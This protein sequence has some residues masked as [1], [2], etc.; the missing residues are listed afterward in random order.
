MTSWW[1][2]PCAADFAD[3]IA[4]DLRAGKSVVVCLPDPHPPGLPDTLRERLLLE[5]PPAEDIDAAGDGG[6][7]MRLLAARCLDR[8]DLAEDD[9][10]ERLFAD[11]RFRG[12]FLFV[13]GIRAETWPRWSAFLS[14]FEE[15]CRPMGLLDRTAIC[16]FLSGLPALSP[17][18]AEVCLSVRPWR[19]Q[20]SEAD[21]L[22]HCWIRVRSRAWP[23]LHRKLAA[24]LAAKVA[25]WDPLIADFLLGRE[26]EDVLD[27]APALQ[28]YARVRGWGN[29][30]RPPDPLSLWAEGKADM[31][32]EE[33]RLHA[34]LLPAGEDVT[35]LRSRIWSAQ[36]SV[37][38]P[39]LEEERRRLIQ[40]HGRR[41]PLPYK[42]PW[43]SVDRV[44][45]LELQHLAKILCSLPRLDLTIRQRAQLLG[46]IR[47]KLAH[48]E[49]L[50]AS[51][52]DSFL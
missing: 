11:A 23:A 29:G 52:F 5:G 51:D 19:G 12:R 42:T 22:H 27:P 33:W 18:P 43:G 37:L 45:D 14:R 15:A 47:N 6:T 4:S 46:K 44:E 31:F 21:M 35:E 41:I 10:V 1:S 17:P 16:V 26:F 9:P 34:A 32:E 24:A 50:E 38:M 25:L 30:S 2:V 48:L 7:P 36:V 49:P 40:K 13:T 8:F 28:E 20:V 39:I 3:Q